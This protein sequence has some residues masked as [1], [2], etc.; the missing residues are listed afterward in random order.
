VLKSRAPEEKEH[1]R[2]QLT[3]T[4]FDSPSNNPI[5]ACTL[6]HGSGRNDAY[7]YGSIFRCGFVGNS[8]LTE[9]NGA[10]VSAFATSK[11]NYLVR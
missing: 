4:L 9:P 5:I 1:F 3:H 10:L 2:H 6:R 7:L 11:G 8:Q